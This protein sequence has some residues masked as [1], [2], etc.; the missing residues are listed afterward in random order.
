MG[1]FWLLT[2]TE[3][4]L[5]SQ[6][7]LQVQAALNQGKMVRQYTAEARG[8]QSLQLVDL[9]VNPNE[10]VGLLG[11][12]NRK[13]SNWQPIQAEQD[14]AVIARGLTALHEDDLEAA[15]DLGVS[16]P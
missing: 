2:I 1:V 10:K 5:S 11:E 15:T 12:N 16:H 8:L 3:P 14:L 4:S 13:Y 9:W 6:K 7:T